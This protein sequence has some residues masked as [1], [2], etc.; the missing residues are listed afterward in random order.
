MAA[1][2]IENAA[3][4]KGTGGRNRTN[5]GRGRSGYFFIDESALYSGAFGVEAAAPSA[6]ETGADFQEG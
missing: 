2:G 3:R 1:T 4:I 6:V 5:G